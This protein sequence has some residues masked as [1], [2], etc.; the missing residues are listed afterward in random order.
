[1]QIPPS[2]SL[3]QALSRHPDPASA[4]R[5]QANPDAAREAARAVFAQIKVVPKPAAT[6][7]AIQAF[8][9]TQPAPQQAPAY[10]PSNTAALPSAAPTRPVPRG[11]FVNIL[12]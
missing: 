2:T 11:S 3:L 8:S 12:V 7:P 6:A 1:M 9:Q 4:P 10:A 5:L